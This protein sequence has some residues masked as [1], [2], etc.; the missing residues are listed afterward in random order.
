M[1]DLKLF[2]LHLGF[3][4]MQAA[5][6]NQFIVASIGA[7][8]AAE[9]Q[10]REP[11]AWAALMKKD[12]AVSAAKPRSKKKALRPPP[13]LEE[14]ISEH[15]CHHLKDVVRAADE[16]HP[17]KK[18]QVSFHNEGAVLLP[19]RAGR[20]ARRVDILAT[21][22]AFLGAPEL[23]FEA[24]VLTDYGDILG[25]YL[26]GKQGIGCFT[27][28]LAPYATGRL[29]AMLAYVETEPQRWITWIREKMAGTP[30]VANALRSVLIHGE[31]DAALCSE[32][33]RTHCGRED[34]AVFH[35]AMTL[36]ALECG[37]RLTAPLQGA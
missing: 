33:D 36:G 7:L 11:A 9:R 28:P 26:D 30:A 21:S 25:K 35:F 1:I 3:D 16:S 24:K 15:L 20:S 18:L 13:P 17:L 6:W 29:G 19:H 14:A 12:G 34:I 23:V 5:I 4:E 27:D 2:L 32:L 8:R 31:V 37:S 10:L 22:G